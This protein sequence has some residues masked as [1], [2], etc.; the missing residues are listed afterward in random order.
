MP[1]HL[2]MKEKTKPKYPGSHESLVPLRVASVADLDKPYGPTSEVISVGDIIFVICNYWGSPTI[3]NVTRGRTVDAK[4]NEK[5][6]CVRAYDVQQIILTN[7]DT[8]APVL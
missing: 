5:I 7:D 8:P 1:I 2:V 3:V 6:S 4:W